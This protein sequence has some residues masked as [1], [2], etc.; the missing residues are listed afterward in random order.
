MSRASGHQRQIAVYY[1]I[2]METHCS[3]MRC[4][5]DYAASRL[6]LETRRWLR[7]GHDRFFELSRVL[8]GWVGLRAARR[9][10]K[11][12]NGRVAARAHCIVRASGTTFHAS[13]AWQRREFGS[14]QID[15]RWVYK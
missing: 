3:Q 7:R 10:L 6:V 4:G 11:Q 1:G 9:A 8:R 5:V 13:A 14:I 2:G 15:R 12:K